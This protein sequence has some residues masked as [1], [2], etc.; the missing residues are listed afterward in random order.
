VDVIWE[1]FGRDNRWMMNLEG[2]RRDNRWM[3]S[4][5]GFGRDNRWMTPKNLILD[6]QSLS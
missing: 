4:W 1:E 5:E 6:N 3:M 2:S